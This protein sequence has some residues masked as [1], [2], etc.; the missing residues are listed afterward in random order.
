[1]PI[2]LP[3]SRLALGLSRTCNCALLDCRGNGSNS[4]NARPR[5]VI[6]KTTIQLTQIMFD[7]SDGGGGCR[8]T[9]KVAALETHNVPVRHSQQPEYQRWVRSPF[10]VR[11]S[12]TWQ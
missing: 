2:T 5:M 4:A 1:M 7:V 8:L 10:M 6:S 9:H 3:T 11:G 12:V